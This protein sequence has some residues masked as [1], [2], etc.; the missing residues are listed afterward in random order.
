MK[1]LNTPDIAFAPG[2]DIASLSAQAAK[3]KADQATTYTHSV[4]SYGQ[5]CHEFS[6]L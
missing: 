3:E 6:C 2:E 1:R 4:G 5:K